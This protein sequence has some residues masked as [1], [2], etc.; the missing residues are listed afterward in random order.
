MSIFSD[1]FNKILDKVKSLV[2]GAAAISDVDLVV[3][4]DKLKDSS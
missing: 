3:E 2:T 1:I 4:L